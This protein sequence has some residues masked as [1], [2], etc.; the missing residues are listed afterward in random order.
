MPKKKKG[1]N[2]KILVVVL[3]I[4]LVAVAII[5][6]HDGLVG[7]TPLGDINNL[8][9][10]SGTTV[11]IKGE[12]TLVIGTWV[13]VADSTGLIG[14]NWANADSLDPHTLVVVRGVVSTPITL[15]DVTSV[16]QV[17]LFA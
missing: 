4:A 16:V 13:T 5:I 15:T 14:F 10:D 9:V 12:V 11:T 2:S 8:Q 7:V 3:L 6:Y 17:W 1:S